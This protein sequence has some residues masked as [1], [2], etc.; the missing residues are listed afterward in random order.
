MGSIWNGLGNSQVKKVGRSLEGG[1]ADQSHWAHSDP[2]PYFRRQRRWAPPFLPSPTSTLGPSSPSSLS[3]PLSLSCSPHPTFSRQNQASAVSP[4]AHVGNRRD[5]GQ[6]RLW[7]GRVALR[8]TQN[9]PSSFSNQS[10][11]M[12]SFWNVGGG[13]PG[14][15]AVAEWWPPH[16]T[17]G[18]HI[19]PQLLVMP[20][21]QSL[22]VRLGQGP[23]PSVSEE[24]WAPVL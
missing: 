10:W 24:S 19:P 14:A 12:Y 23:P 9:I 6:V 4:T 22:R 20:P 13:R 16:G 15:E 7:Q 18:P 17:Q 8:S 1:G 3:P 11:S 2:C 21:T 5:G